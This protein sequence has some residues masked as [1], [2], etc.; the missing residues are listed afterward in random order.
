MEDPVTGLPDRRHIETTLAAEF[1]RSGWGRR[2]SVVKVDIDGFDWYNRRHG[3]LAGDFVLF[4][5]GSVLE[6]QGPKR[7]VVGRY[8]DDEF[9]VLLP[10]TGGRRALSYAKRVTVDVHS[11]FGG[12]GSPVTVSCGVASRDA[13]MSR[14]SQLLERADSALRAAKCLGGNAVGLGD[15]RSTVTSLRRRPPAVADRTLRSA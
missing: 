7:N 1:E 14:P 5:V 13:S 4:V 8:G 12:T 2:C 9:V 15:A 3:D 10:R 11:Q 6:L